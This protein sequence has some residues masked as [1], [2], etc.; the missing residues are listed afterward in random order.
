MDGM[1]ISSLAMFL[2]DNLDFFKDSTG[3]LASCSVTRGFPS[4]P[5]KPS[6]VIGVRIAGYEQAVS[7]NITLASNAW[8][9]VATEVSLIMFSALAR[10]RGYSS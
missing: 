8:R 2:S 10:R 5:F 1:K 9:P 6:T 4:G 7:F 3:M